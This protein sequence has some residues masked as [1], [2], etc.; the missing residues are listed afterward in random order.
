[1]NKQ[2]AMVVFTDP[3]YNVPIDDNASEWGKKQHRD[4]AMACDEMSRAEFTDFLRTM[5]KRLV[6]ASR[7]GSIHFICMDWR[8][9]G[10]L[11]DAGKEMYDKVKNICVWVKDDAAM[12]SLYRSQ[13]EFILVFKHGKHSHRNNVQRGNSVATGAMSGS[14]RA[15]NHLPGQPQR[16]TCSASTS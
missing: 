3:R 2:L 12:G 4:C 6:S 11:L 13:H 5:C 9:V 7:G 16:G 14:T 8:H 1:M 10:E 15:R